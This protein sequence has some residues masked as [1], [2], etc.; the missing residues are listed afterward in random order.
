MEAGMT[1]WVFKS[2]GSVQCETGDIS[3]DDARSEL[4]EIVGEQN[5][6]DGRKLN[7][8][9]FHPTLCGAP[10]GRV[11]AFELTDEGWTRFLTGFVGQLGWRR[12]LYPVPEQASSECQSSE[13]SLLTAALST[14]SSRPAGPEVPFPLGANLCP[15]CPFPM[16]TAKEAST[17]LAKLIG[18]EDCPIPMSV[19]PGERSPRESESRIPKVPLAG[20]VDLLHQATDVSSTPVL[21]R[22]LAGYFLRVIGPDDVITLDYN[23]SRVNVFL[24]SS[25]RI[26]RITF[27]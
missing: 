19:D 12:W 18:C 20:A 7:L 3:L 23:P 21:I 17:D 15:E 14:P 2:D 5:I 11:N 4:G 9:G 27:G 24:D 6:G 8:P 22:E 1:I 25:D 10:T 16:R 13:T 26:Q